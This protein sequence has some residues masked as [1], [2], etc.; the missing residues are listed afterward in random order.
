MA[1]NKTCTEAEKRLKDSLFRRYILPNVNMVYKLCIKYTFNREHIQ[2]NYVDVLTNLYKYILTY[3]ESKSIQ[4]WIHICTKRHVHTLDITRA[5]KEMKDDSVSVDMDAIADTPYDIAYDSGN[6]VAV[7]LNNY[8]E[9]YDDEI[10]Y[11]LGQLK[12]SY[13]RAF[14]LQQAGYQLKE[15]AEIEYHAGALKT[16][17]IE[18]VKTRLFLA[19][20]QLKEILTRNGKLRALEESGVDFQKI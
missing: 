20:K 9:V 12:E 7:T 10:V 3:D 5:K 15:I 17:N 13:R 18:T 6:D 16:N 4:T 2:D 1:K 8:K 19:R 14:L 11:A